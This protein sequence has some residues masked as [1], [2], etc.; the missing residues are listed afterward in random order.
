[1][2]YFLYCRKSS[3]D[4][5]RQI[6][7]IES[8]RREMERLVSSW[9]DVTIVGLF[10]ESRSARAPGRPIF[11]E[12]LRRIEK[13]DADGIIAWHPDRL[14]RNSVDGGRIIYL[15][16]RKKLKDLRF[17]TFTFENNPQGKFMLSITFGYSKYYVDSLSENIRRGNRTK[18]ENGWR[19]CSVPIGYRN[20][21]ETATTIADPE[22][23]SLTRQMWDLMLTGAYSPRRIR[24]I[25][26]NDWGL[27]TR[28]RKRVG[29]APL[30]LSAVYKVFTNS[31]YAGVIQWEGRSYPGK[32]PH[33]V[34]LDEFERVQELL[35][36]PGRP[37]NKRHEF[38]FTGMIR[39][40]E[41]GFSITADRRRNR[42][43]SLYTYYHCT[44]KRTDYRCQQPYM[45]LA[46]LEGQIIAF[47]EQIT[48]PDRFHEWLLARLD[49]TEDG[50]AD[51]SLT[52]RNSVLEAQSTVA[53]QLDNLTKLRVRDMVTDEEYLRQRSELEQE[54][55]RLAQS[56]VEMEKQGS[57]LEPEQKFISFSNRA[58]PWF[59]SGGLLTKR[60][61]L[62]I[63]GL[64]P[65]L[66]DKT[67]SI[68][69]KKPFRLWPDAGD[70]SQMWRF[71]EDVR[72]FL[73]QGTEEVNVMVARIHRLEESVAADASTQHE[74][75]A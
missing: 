61:I 25:A 56:L 33:M 48:I 45:P 47:L 2:N 49:R 24:D 18:I 53:R 14:A 68:E 10:E 71:R 16:D 5:G 35:G 55:M 63:V 74:F 19:P 17:A 41:C 66:K 21:K 15:L 30:T 62:E 54:Q 28:K 37:R 65:T 67:L 34:T 8:Q 43:G 73:H 42:F 52:R 29:G 27:R 31:F 9:K 13:G 44:Q 20:D 26:T 6:L 75:V 57:R 58:V 23:F 72:T 39:C 1:M 59:K 51:D 64:N 3:E 12:M 36:R 46:R 4:E 32:H 50:K 40:G 22:R 38:A 11:D 70:F 69:A 60:L 7:S